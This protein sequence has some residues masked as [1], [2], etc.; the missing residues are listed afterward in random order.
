[1]KPS[2]S[3]T[4]TGSLKPDS[5]SSVLASLRVRVDPRSNEKIAAPSVDDRIAPSSRPS[6]VENPNK[7]AAASPKTPAVIIVPTVA[8]A[9]EAPSTGRTCNRPLVNPPSNRIRASAITPIVR[10]SR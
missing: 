6:L 1:M 3:S 5:P 10:A 9:V 7:A 8:S 4:A 2:T